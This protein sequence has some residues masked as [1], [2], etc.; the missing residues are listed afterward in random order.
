MTR[1]YYKDAHGALIVFDCTR[2]NTYDGAL[3]WKTD[4][5]SKITLATEKPLPSILVANK[6]L[7]LSS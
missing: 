2:Q 6:V 7:Y 4:L 5:D 3:R 1:V